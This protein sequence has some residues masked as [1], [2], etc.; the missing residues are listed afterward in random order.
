M[1]L[2]RHIHKLLSEYYR[3]PHNTVV[4][5]IPQS[6]SIA[7][8]SLFGE[9]HWRRIYGKLYANQSGQWLTP[10]ELFRPFYSQILG[11]YIVQEGKGASKIHIV[12]IGGGRGTNAKCILDYLQQ[13]HSDVYDCLDYTIMDASPTLLELQ[14][15]VLLK[16]DEGSGEHDR[17]LHLEQVDML[18]VAERRVNFMEESNTLTIVI[19]NELLDNLPH[20]KLSSCSKTGAF[21]QANILKDRKSGQLKESF[22]PLDDT[23][24]RQMVDIYPSCLPNSGPKWVPTVATQVLTRIF[25]QRPNAGVVFADFDY[26]PPP[27]IMST[28]SQTRLSQ[29][30]EGEPLVTDMNDVDHECYLS[31]PPLC[32]ILFPTDFDTLHGYLLATL[33]ETLKGRRD[34]RPWK[35]DVRKQN[36]FLAL[37]GPKEVEETKSWTGF[38]P[39]LHDFSNCSVLNVSR[40]R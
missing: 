28:S 21:L 5:S 19:A 13:K 4:G 22:V 34:V 26:L 29:R 20:D 39:L 8:K 18:D 30:A 10:V 32:D 38:S 2:R 27:D 35:V 31:S 7:F 25:E 11:N 15:N 6:K 36:D 16:S 1:I 3:Q 33:E 40:L 23:L 12:E 24:L 17:I 9:L 37:Y 14:R